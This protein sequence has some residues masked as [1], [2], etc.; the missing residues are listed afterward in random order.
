[1]PEASL[2]GVKAG[3]ER[4]GVCVVSGL[5]DPGQLPHAIDAMDRVIQADYETGVT[6]WAVNW[7][8]GDDP[9]RLVKI[10]QPQMADH[11]IT[12]L[13]LNSKIGEVA[14]ALSGADMVQVWAVQLLHKPGAASDAG[15][16]GWHQDDDY[17]RQWWDWEVFTCW[18][19][20]SD[21]TLDAGPV[22][23][24]PG[25]HRWGFLGKGNFFQSDLESAKAE[26]G[27]PEGEEWHEFPAIVAPGG[28]SFHHRT[29]IHGSGPNFSACPRRSYAVHLR[30]ERSRHLPDAPQQYVEQLDDPAISPVL[31]QR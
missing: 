1:M 26:F 4:D 13:L 28:G 8:P 29:T 25:S 31:F 5:V 21:V 10:D 9:S 3:Y 30:T 15:N 20:L 6:P 22:R 27:I 16:V 18:L 17:W 24:I 11:G 7:H 2:P 12:D 23:F 14:A 19:A